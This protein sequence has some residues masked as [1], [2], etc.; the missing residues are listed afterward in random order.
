[1]KWV[2]AA[3]TILL[4]VVWI[5]SRWHRFESFNGAGY[6]LGVTGGQLLILQPLVD[7]PWDWHWSFQTYEE[8]AL[9]GW[10]FDRNRWPHSQVT[11]VPLWFPALISLLATAAAWR[12]DFAHRRRARA[13][14]CS[15]CNYDRAGLAPNAVCP[16]CGSLPN[17]N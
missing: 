16:E 5:G 17:S 9:F 8:L 7:L 3:A 11:Q 10:W 2:G 4:L 12:A 1:M 14:T 6:G 15:S 13:G